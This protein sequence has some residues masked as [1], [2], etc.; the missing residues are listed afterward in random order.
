[1]SR[2]PLIAFA[3][4]AAVS[5]LLALPAR[6]DFADVVRT[7]EAKA[8]GHK[9]PIPLFGLVRFAVWMIHPDGVHDIE[10]ATWEGTHVSVDAREIASVVRSRSGAGYQ[11]VVASRSR[12]GEWTYIYARPARGDLLDVILVTHDNDDTV[13]IRAVL[14][15]RVFADQVGDH[16]HAAKIAG[17]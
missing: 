9:T 5:G 10:L 11:P 8:G 2:Q 7:V 16:H 14:E 1:M 13:A 4:V 15:P 12:N 17:R 6:A 3:V